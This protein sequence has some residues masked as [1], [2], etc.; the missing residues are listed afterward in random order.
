M[1]K[2]ILSLGVLLSSLIGLNAYGETSKDECNLFYLTYK[3][4]KDYADDYP[5][6]LGAIYDGD[7]KEIGDASVV[8]DGHP[9][10]FEDN[11]VI[12]GCKASV[13]DAIWVHNGKNMDWYGCVYIYGKGNLCDYILTGHREDLE[14]KS[15]NSDHSEFTGFSMPEGTA[16]IQFVACATGSSSLSADSKGKVYVSQQMLFVESD[17]AEYVVYG[18]DGAM[19]YRGSEYAL[20]MKPGVYVVNINGAKVKVAVP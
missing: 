2:A 18:V 1:K 19:V 20:S 8:C 5:S 13:G 7:W 14:T 3:N 16:F 11:V 4:A 10:G 9:Y 15:F 17:G 12:Y 6:D